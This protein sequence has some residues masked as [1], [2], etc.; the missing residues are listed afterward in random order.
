EAGHQG[1]RRLVA[2]APEAGHDRAG[3]GDLEG[4]LQAEQPIA[5]GRLPQP[6]LAGRQYGELAVRQ[7]ERRDLQ[8]GEDAVVLARRRRLA[9]GPGQGDPREQV[10]M[11]PGDALPPERVDP[12][13]R[14]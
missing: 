6:G 3:A 8:R 13:S 1:T 12:G 4:T 14:P 9:V 11:E 2:D 10:G 5:A 7:V